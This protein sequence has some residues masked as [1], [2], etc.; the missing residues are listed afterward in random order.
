[1]IVFILSFIIIAMCIL[2]MSLSLL[3]GRGPIK[4]SCGATEDIPGLDAG[5]GCTGACGTKHLDKE[6][7]CARRHAR[8]EDQA[9]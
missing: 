4:G 2:G 7:V 3:Y 5:D 8:Q 9:V 1:M 6:H